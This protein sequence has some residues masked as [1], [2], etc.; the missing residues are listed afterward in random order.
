MFATIVIIIAYLLVL[1]V[2]N[3]LWGIFLRIGLR[4]A[5]VQD[6][7][8]RKLIVTVLLVLALQTLMDVL[9]LRV[10]S[11]NPRYETHIEVFYLTASMLIA[12]LAIRNVFKIKFQ[13]AA[14]AWAFTLIPTIATIYLFIP[15]VVYQYVWEQ[16]SPSTTVMAPTL[17]GGHWEAK[18]AVCGNTAYCSPM[19]FAVDDARPNMICEG[20]FHV[21]Q[22]ASN[23]KGFHEADQFMVAKFIRP[24][25]WDVVMFLFPR[26]PTVIQFSR[27]VGLPGEEVTIR[28]GQLFVNGSPIKPPDE[29][30]GLKYSTDLET[31]SDT[32]V[33]GSPDHP[34]KLADDEYFVL[35]D[36]SQQSLDSRF[37]Q[38]GAPGHHPYAVPRSHLRGVVVNICAPRSRW[39][40]FP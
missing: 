16:R 9:H 28:D 37:W 15:F 23:D 1:L 5:K 38:L 11:A 29:L 4:W 10:A 14:I 18:C 33:W 2:S 24:K 30:R 8:L 6:V 3:V 40:T 12:C 32:T 26:N 13:R 34:A 19:P 27:L 7:T 17:L 31:G 21:T 35:G 22:P 36:F 20:N 25:R 39:R